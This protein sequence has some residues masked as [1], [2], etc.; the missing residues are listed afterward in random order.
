M[1]LVL[2]EFGPNVS[3]KDLNLV[4]LPP[5]V[6]R[7]ERERIAVYAGIDDLDSEEPPNLLQPGILWPRSNGA[8]ILGNVDLVKRCALKKTRDFRE[9]IK[10]PPL[11]VRNAIEFVL[12]I[13]LR[14]ISGIERR[15]IQVRV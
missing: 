4:R 12:A 2:L 8:D 11:R 9:D 13:S 10:K 6:A 5:P 3:Q 14:F 7:E 15:T 1:H